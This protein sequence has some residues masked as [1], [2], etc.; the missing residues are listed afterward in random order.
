VHRDLKLENLLLDGDRNVIVTDFGFANRSLATSPITSN[1]SKLMTTSCGS[2][3]YAAPELVISE[4]YVGESADVWSCG[5]ILFAM[6]CGYLPYDDDPRNPDGDNINLLYKYILE[7]ELVV[8]DYLSFDA[9]HLLKRILVPDPNNRAKLEE[10]FRHPWLRENRLV[11]EE[12]RAYTQKTLEEAAAVAKSTSAVVPSTELTPTIEDD[13]DVDDEEATPPALQTPIIRELTPPMQNSSSA[14]ITNDLTPKQLV[15]IGDDD[16]PKIPDEPIIVPAAVVHAAL[17]ETIVGPV[18]TDN[19]VDSDTIKRIVVPSMSLDEMDIEGVADMAVNHVV[20]NETSIPENSAVIEPMIIHAPDSKDPLISSEEMEPTM[21]VQGDEERREVDIAMFEVEESQVYVVMPTH[22][23]PPPSPSP[24]LDTPAPPPSELC[25]EVKDITSTSEFIVRADD[26]PHSSLLIEKSSDSPIT[27]AVTDLLV[28]QSRPM[29]PETVEIPPRS[30][31]KCLDKKSVAPTIIEEVIALTP[32][33]KVKPSV[34]DTETVKLQITSTGLSSTSSGSGGELDPSIK[35]YH[36]IMNQARKGSKSPTKPYEKSPAVI[37]SVT[38]PAR[39]NMDSAPV[40]HSISGNRADI[41]HSSASNSILSSNGI[42]EEPARS[43]KS[44]DVWTSG[45]HEKRGTAS[46]FKDF[47]FP[48]IEEEDIQALPRPSTA[49]KHQPSRTSMSS[50]KPYKLRYHS[51][52][53][54]QRALTSK[55]P[56]DLLADIIIMLRENGLYVRQSGSESTSFK[57][58]VVRPAS[59]LINPTKEAVFGRPEVVGSEGLTLSRNSIPS[60]SSGGFMKNL[61]SFPMSFVKRIKY[62]AKYGSSWNKGFDGKESS[63]LS[64]SVAPSEAPTEPEHGEIKFYI[65]IQKIRNLDGLYVV[66][67]KR[68]QGDI[69]EFK[70]MYG[71]LVEKMRLDFPPRS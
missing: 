22:S 68:R 8:P 36:T 6:L 46:K 71:D 55:P 45:K 41:M 19:F 27:S 14:T 54:D 31:V 21:I 15:P 33:A 7:T 67:F 1:S 48:I 63:E 51:G 29:T 20:M 4:G 37:A 16:A 12:S 66:E 52:A 13:M 57:L 39:V 60:A 3:C 5:V 18:V 62:R 28:P 11:I 42:K 53:I 32:V 64:Q 10:I 49:S 35:L 59:L 34:I 17:E 58:K 40:R 47:A 69:W 43:R 23:A 65:E 26:L 61:S 24:P 2:P 9:T 38:T 50:N 30:M 44:F 56:I 25:D 70:R